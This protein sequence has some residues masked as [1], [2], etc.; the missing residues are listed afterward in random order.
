MGN[1]DANGVRELAKAWIAVGAQSFG[2]GSSTLF[3]IRR[4]IV[5]RAR[6]ITPREFNEAWAIAQLSPGIHLVALAGMLGQRIAGWRGV[7]VSVLGMIVPAA[8]V[9][10]VLTAL[11]G[12]LA[13]HP[14]ALAALSGMA[15]ATGGMTLGLALLMFRDTRRRG[16]AALLDA[17]LVLAAFALL[18]L[19]GAS[20]VL[21]I[22][23]AAIVGA[24]LLGRERP[25]RE[26][27]E[28]E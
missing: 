1:G 22:V 12:S 18:S 25:T 24:L 9:T 14:L 17:G 19:A 20:S 16:H 11:Y 21:V 5:D 3:L 7:A 4:L 6:W 27:R 23:V 8:A 10:A 15:P 2:G 13:Q 28:D 26:V